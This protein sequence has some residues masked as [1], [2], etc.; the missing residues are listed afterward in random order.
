MIELQL[1]V[2]HNLILSANQT[3]QIFVRIRYACHTPFPGS[4]FDLNVLHQLTPSS[5]F[6]TMSSGRLLNDDLLLLAYQTINKFNN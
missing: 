4:V 1:A 2:H 6:P 3:R 5:N